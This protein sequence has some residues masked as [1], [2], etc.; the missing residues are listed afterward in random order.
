MI[1]DVFGKR[2]VED[3]LLAQRLLDVVF[4]E[5]ARFEHFVPRSV[6]EV[7]LE[8]VFAG[9]DFGVAD[10]DFVVLGVLQDQRFLDHLLQVLRGAWAG[11]EFVLEGAAG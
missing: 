1:V 4:A 11:F 8:L 10:D 3:D 5:T 9:G 2:L 6:R 7:G